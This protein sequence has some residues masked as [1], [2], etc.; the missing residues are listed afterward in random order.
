MTRVGSQCHRKKKEIGVASL[1]TLRHN[2]STQASEI[3]PYMCGFSCT[4]QFKLHVWFLLY[5]SVVCA[6]VTAADLLCNIALPLP[7]SR[8]NPA[9]ETDY[10]SVR[11][12]IFLSGETTC[13]P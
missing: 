5:N 11:K 2:L 6:I 7:C 3:L 1:I 8:G 10:M 13:C 4:N 9:A 12:L